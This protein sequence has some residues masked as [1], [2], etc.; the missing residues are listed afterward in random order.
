MAP[1][2]IILLAFTLDVVSSQLVSP[3]PRLFHYEPQNNENDRWYGE[4]TLISDSDLT[5]LWLRVIFDRQSVQ[6][7]VSQVM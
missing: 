4:M 7:G 5:G 1:V 2:F 6:L 3:C